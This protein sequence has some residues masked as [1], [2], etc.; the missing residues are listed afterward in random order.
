[1]IIFYN[2]KTGEIVGTI[3][4][5]IHGE[6]HLKMWVG[7]KEENDR[8][9]I[10]WKPGKEHFEVIERDV[11]IGGTEVS[12]KTGE[13]WWKP[14]IKRVKEKIKVIDYEPDHVQKEIWVEIEKNQSVIKKYKVDLK[15]KELTL[16]S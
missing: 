16:K 9:I 15:T 1:M 8:V 4:G 10:Q 13:V 6:D 12:D 7:T 5:R 2:K 3:D 11:E 14:T